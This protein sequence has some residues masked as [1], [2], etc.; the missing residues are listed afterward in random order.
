MVQ[1]R[2]LFAVLVVAATLSVVAITT[3]AVY[4]ANSTTTTSTARPSGTAGAV[5]QACALLTPDDLQSVLG[6]TVGAGDLTTAPKGGETICEWTVV[7]AANGSGYGAQ[8]DVK[9]P[10]TSKEF[11][12]QRQNAG[13]PTQTVKR[14]GDAAFSERAKIGHQVFDD[15]WVRTGTVAFRLEVLKD[16]GPKPLERLAPVVLTNLAST[17]GDH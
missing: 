10:F 3:P 14:L 1:R 15:L 4:A 9:T 8:L 16:L 17:A 2:Q 6:G 13:G 11:K 12:Q 5:A 7:T